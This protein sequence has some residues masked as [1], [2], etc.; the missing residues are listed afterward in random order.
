MKR[1]MR[2]GTKITIISCFAAVMAAIS[3]ALVTIIVFM[4]FVKTIQED[5]TAT[6]IN[7]L[8]AEVE[9]DIDEMGDVAELFVAS[10]DSQT[11]NTDYDSFWAANKPN[12]N[13]YA[14]YINGGAVAWSSEGFPL[15]ESAVERITNGEIKGI[16]ADGDKLYTVYGLK[17]ENGALVVCIDLND[18]E[19]VDS[20]KAKTGAELTLFCG[21]T[22]Y[23]TTL[24]NSSGERNIG[25]QMDGGIWQQVQGNNTYIGKTV[26]GGT[27]YYVNYTPMVDYSGEVVG[28]YFAGYI[29]A[30]ADGELIKSILVSLGVLIIVC[31][32]IAVL[33][34]GVMKKLVRK[35]VA[36][37]VNICGQLRSVE[38]N[39]PDSA[40]RFSGDEM[41]DIAENLTEAKH[42]LSSYVDDISRVLS[43]MGTGDF[44]AQPSMEYVGSFEE[45]NRSFR[46]IKETLSNV[47][48]SMN[49]SASNVTA[50][51]Q[52]MADGSQILA[53][54]TTHQATAVDKLSS[55]ISGIS[56]NISK[57][58]E[59][60]GRASGLSDNCAQQ[61][62]HQSEDM[63]RLLEAM[64][65]IQ[66]QSE[67]ISQVIT[68]IEDIAF[69][70]N[71]LALN[72]AIE[73][74]R[75]GE[76]GKGFAVVADEVRN[77]ASKSAEFANSTRNLIASTI[78][79]VDNG[80]DIAKQTAETLRQVT[81]LSQESAKLVADIS[82]AAEEQANAVR[83]VTAGID[84][85]SRVIATNSATAEETAASCEELSAQARLLNEQ[86]EKLH[87]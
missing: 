33:L 6:G 83:Q 71:I 22:R 60:S 64:D 52:Q 84:Q 20:V 82:V 86:V 2:I 29:T 87:V 51:S 23:N 41:G 36:E 54:G 56:D 15:G 31:G 69:Q 85:I 63:E 7:V 45:I 12:A 35:P 18:S 38:L 81:E 53:E 76:A 19:Y 3:M 17:V 32:G 68:S 44:S 1:S 79:A 80:S 74:A 65:K 58:A 59:N 61:M 25:T 34:F 11:S 9:G 4:S 8:A 13:S 24:I 47:I 14:A 16:M 28:A 27:N 40:F 48:L 57:T 37:V 78:E 55:T 43:Q 26:I 10:S 62:M 39:A 42:T 67:A 73:A 66:K 72:A 5:E 75:A 77:L 49:S 46:S 70:T 50:G 30:K 21:D